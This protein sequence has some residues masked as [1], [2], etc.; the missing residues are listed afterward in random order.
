M[1]QTVNGILAHRASRRAHCMNDLI[2]LLLSGGVVTATLGSPGIKSVCGGRLA[3]LPA[4]MVVNAH[5]GVTQFHRHTIRFS[6]CAGSLGLRRALQSAAW[7][8]QPHCPLTATGGLGSAQLPEQEGGHAPRLLF[9]RH[10]RRRLLKTSPVASRPTTCFET[11]TS[12]CTPRL[13]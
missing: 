3:T 1:R 9:F 11:S 6:P 13:I 4:S 2:V 10:Q 8:H 12:K 5:L 7:F